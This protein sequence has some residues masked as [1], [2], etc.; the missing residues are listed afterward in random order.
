MDLDLERYIEILKNKGVDTNQVEEALELIISSSAS[1][2]P[3]V[4][5]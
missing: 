3:P 1:E 4:A 5:Q 2:Q